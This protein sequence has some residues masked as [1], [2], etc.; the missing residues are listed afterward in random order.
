MLLRLSRQ[1]RHWF[2]R[3]GVQE[4]KTAVPGLLM[5]EGIDLSKWD[6]FFIP[7]SASHVIDF[8]IQKLTEGTSYIDQALAQ[9]W[10]GVQ[11]IGIR[12]AYHYMKSG[13]S[14]QAQADHFLA[15][16]SFYSF[17]FYAC[18]VE[19]YSNTYSDTFFADV[20]RWID[21]VRA[22]SGKKVV[23]YTNNSTYT[24][25]LSALKRL[26]GD[27]AAVA[28]MN[29]LDYWVAYPTTA[30]A[31]ILPAGAGWKLHQYSWDGLGWGT[32]GKADVNVFNGTVADMR[33]WASVTDEV[34]PVVPSTNPKGKVNTASLYIRTGPGASYESSGGLV[35]DDRIEAS[36]ILG[37]W[38]HLTKV[39]GLPVTGW[40]SSAYILWDAPTPTDPPATG[41]TPYTLIVEG[42][43]PAEG[44]L[45]PE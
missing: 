34:P 18:D 17:H 20:K 43:K 23:L 24:A 4:Q 44:M 31:P 32:V 9:I 45:Y 27:A 7:E 36:E 3:L 25:M 35:R 16:A 38:A 19:Q 5:A 11:K 21:Y 6:E 37:G 28:W 26:Y 12:G 10:A 8:V 42:M 39:N 14:W 29:A 2:E 33:A 13:M 40:C 22:K 15:V 1:V 30:G 41:G